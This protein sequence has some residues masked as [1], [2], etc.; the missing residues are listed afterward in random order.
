[1]LHLL[2][3]ERPSMNGFGVTGTY[4]ALILLFCNQVSYLQLF[5]PQLLMSRC[6]V[7]SAAV[8]EPKALSQRLKL[9]AH[10]KCG[11]EV[12]AV[13]QIQFTKMNGL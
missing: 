12:A 7:Y 3:F 9:C 5:L 6:S 10:T 8:F 2:H 1:M 13:N 4:K 11:P